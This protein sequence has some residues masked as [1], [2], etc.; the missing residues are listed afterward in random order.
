MA[1]L[2]ARQVT[3]GDPWINAAVDAASRLD[4]ESGAVVVTEA[5][6]RVTTR[7]ED[8]GETEIGRRPAA[9]LERV[10][11]VSPRAVRIGGAARPHRKG[12]RDAVVAGESERLGGRC[13]R[14]RGGVRASEV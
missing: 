8:V 14:H 5:E 11:G 10:I 12:G 4:D 9:Q 1:R 2:D 13:R 7:R 6:E 3:T